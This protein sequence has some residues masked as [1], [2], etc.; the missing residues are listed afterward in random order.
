[1]LERAWRFARAMLMNS[2]ARGTNSKR[3]A[4]MFSRAFAT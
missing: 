1:M 3:V 4:R 2:N